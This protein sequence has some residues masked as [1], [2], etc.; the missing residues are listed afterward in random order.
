MIKIQPWEERIK[1]IDNILRGKMDELEKN[2]IRKKDQER[3]MKL[4]EVVN[5]SADFISMMAKKYDFDEK[6]LT[7]QVSVLIL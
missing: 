3:R 5:I 4:I 7:R 6:E 1:N 2:I